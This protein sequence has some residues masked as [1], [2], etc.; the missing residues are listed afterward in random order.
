MDTLYVV[1]FANLA[2]DFR[3]V[4][5]QIFKYFVIISNN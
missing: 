1:E 4:L 5:P 3:I 2:K